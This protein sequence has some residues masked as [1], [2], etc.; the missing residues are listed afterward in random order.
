[1]SSL[2]LLNLDNSYSGLPDV[3]F[4]DVSPAPFSG[5]KLA[6]F[7][8]KAA[9][10]LNLNLN[11]EDPQTIADYFCG[12]LSLPGSRPIASVYAGHQFGV[13]V[14]QLGDGRAIILGDI[15]NKNQERWEIQLKGS[16]STPYSR[17]ADGRAVLR[18]TIREYLASEAMHG[19]G[20]PSTRALALVTSDE[21]VYREEIETAAMLTRL[22]PSHIRFG[23]FEFFHHR[24]EI[25]EVRTLAD[26]LL[27]NH[28]NECGENEK[29]YTE[30][31]KTIVSSTAKLIALWQS[32]GFAHGVLNTDNMSIL[33]LTLDYG[34]YAF[35]DTYQKG[36]ICNSSDYQ[37]RYAFDR[38]P[39]IGLWNLNAL[40][41]GFSSLVPREELIT[42]L[43]TYEDIFLTHYHTRMS[44]KLGFNIYYQQD[45]ILISD[46][47]ALM[48]REK[49]DY[50][51]FFRHLSHYHN[52]T[53][54]DNLKA[55]FKSREGKESIGNWLKKY[56]DRLE[57]ENSRDTERSEKMLKINPKYILRNYI[58]EEIITAA[59]ID[60]NFKPL[61]DYLLVLQE[62]YSE[63]PDF[64]HYAGAPPDWSKGISISCS[65]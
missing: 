36:F 51:L 12:N 31:F 28:F 64:E 57:A 56:Q 29:P 13:Y 6:S 60:N 27:E 9:D 53:P 42:A 40:A 11:M 61:N 50:T 45:D 41:H 35:M 18:S 5:A 37:G 48:T 59:R 55:L 2:E 39:A 8:Q 15:T 65:S 7:N 20:I 17:H 22:A 3:F 62:P 16:G 30:L 10:L 49:T 47:L 44:E 63:H 34:P 21:P 26:Y 19:L 32:V 24:M 25:D 23:T 14:P 58:A 1:M 38:Q 4:S 46:L 52:N 54:N 43:K 33:G